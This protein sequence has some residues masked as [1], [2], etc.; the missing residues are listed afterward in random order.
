MDNFNI[1]QSFFCMQ[2]YRNGTKE[3][4]YD[5]DSGIR[6]T[7]QDL[8]IR[9]Y[10][11]A[12]FLKKEIKILK[13]DRVAILSRHDMVYVDTFFYTIYKGAIPTTY[14]IHLM[15]DDL[16]SLLQNEQPKVIF[17]EKEYENKLKAIQA[18]ISVQHFVLLDGNDNPFGPHLYHQIMKYYC[19][20]RPHFTDL[21]M[22]DIILLMHTGGTTGIPKAAK[23]SCRAQFLNS[24]GQQNTWNLSSNDSTIAYLPMFHTATWNTL[25]M[26]VLYAGGRFVLMKKF[27]PSVLMHIIASEKISLIWGV[28]STYRR[29]MDDPGFQY[30]DF[31]SLVWCR[32]GAAPPSLDI[33]ERYWEKGIT[34]CNGYGMTETSPGTL[35]MPV[36]SMT[37]D[38]IRSKRT[39]CGKL[40]PYN[41]A[42]I[43]DSSGSEVPAGQQGELLFRGNLLFSGYWNNEEETHN[44]MPDGWIH[45]GDI[46]MVDQD[47][48]FYVVGRKK[49][50]FI[51][52]GENIYPSEIE[53]Y[54]YDHPA[55]D[56]TCVIGVPDRRRGEVGKALVV[57]KPGMELTKDE[58]LTFLKQYL[59]T[60][61][62]P[63]YVQFID[64][65]PKNAVGKV[66]LSIV[67]SL[68]GQEDAH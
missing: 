6:Y 12:N 40:M 54:I 26:P 50:T 20:S 13:N 57:L 23:L 46:G 41:E 55:V 43:I 8:A 60:I 3:A 10:R 49:N 4:I 21:N 61:K 62:V 48:F 56:D 44:I 65:I 30:A 42:K 31:S 25:V 39:S 14:N 16:A 58:L 34:F 68:Y 7:Y 22:E 35:S 11:L 17:Y 53:N 1:L 63:M 29:I 45:T 15:P 66:M 38:E 9:S 24:V 51:S 59:P 19:D 18:K 2:M 36:A 67:T 32:C 37:L 64:S 5:Y 27:I 52:N 28:P 47:G 33:M